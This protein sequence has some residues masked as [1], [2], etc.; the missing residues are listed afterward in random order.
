MPTSGANYSSMKIVGDD[1]AGNKERT[2]E[3]ERRRHINKV[4]KPVDGGEWGRSAPAVEA[5][6]NPQMNGV[7]FPAGVLQ[8]PVF[9]LKNGCR[10]QLWR[11]RGHHRPRTPPRL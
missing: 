9:D 1:F 2:H 4:G 5:Y 7:N 8:P 3:F 6:F 11:Y 10:S